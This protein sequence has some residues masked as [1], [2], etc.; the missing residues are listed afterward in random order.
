MIRLEE[1]TR[2]LL[3]HL[4]NHLAGDKTLSEIKEM[5]EHIIDEEYYE[6]DYYVLTDS[7]ADEL[8]NEMIDDYIDDC[9]LCELP[10]AYRNYFDSEAFKNDCS[11][12]GRGH[13]I[14]SY[15]GQETE[16]KVN[17]TWYY[18]YRIN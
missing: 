5:N 15:D 7:E 12:D 17:D 11:F 1:K 18:I 6:I 14:S 16:E 8:W 9:V 10:E 3:N 2:A 13:T 4:N